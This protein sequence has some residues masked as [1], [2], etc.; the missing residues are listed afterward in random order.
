M[1]TH[2]LAKWRNYFEGDLTAALAAY[3]GGIGNSMV[4]KELSGDDPDLF[5]ESIRY[6]ETRDYIRYFT[7]NFEIYKTI[8][9]H[10]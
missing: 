9:T 10:P 1:G 2:Y 5:L 7:E 4:W 3:N 6:D 8:Y